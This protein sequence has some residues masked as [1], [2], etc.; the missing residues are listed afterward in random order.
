MIVITGA[1]IRS[2]S[3]PVRLAELLELWK[4]QP[5]SRYDFTEN[6]E[7]FPSASYQYILYGMSQHTQARE[8]QTLFENQA[9]AEQLFNKV[10]QQKQQFLQGLPT[11]RALINHYFQQQN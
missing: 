6:E 1:I 4:Y 9:I 10:Q 2:S 7:I 5:P 8:H 11:N 3:I